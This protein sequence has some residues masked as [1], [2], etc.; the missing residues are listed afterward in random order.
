M[1]GDLSCNSQVIHLVQVRKA[2]QWIKLFNCQRPLCRRR[3][4]VRS[5]QVPVYFTKSKI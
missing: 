1:D 3:E 4:V 2:E 5:R